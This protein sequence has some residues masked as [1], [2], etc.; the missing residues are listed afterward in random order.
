M[1]RVITHEQ[2]VALGLAPVSAPVK[3]AQPAPV[4]KPFTDNFLYFIEEQS[5]ITSG[6]AAMLYTKIINTLSGQITNHLR[7][8]CILRKSKKLEDTALF[9]EMNADLRNE[10]DENKRGEE[11]TNYLTDASGHTVRMPHLKA[12]GILNGIRHAVYDK[13]AGFTDVPDPAVI[14]YSI[15]NNVDPKALRA[16]P[17][18]IDLALRGMIDRAGVPTEAQ[19]AQAHLKAKAFQ[20][21]T[22]L[23]DRALELETKRQQRELMALYPD[24]IAEAKSLPAHDNEDDWTALDAIEREIIVSRVKNNL[25]RSAEQAFERAATARPGSDWEGQQEERLKDCEHA[26]SIVDAW[27]EMHPFKL[28]ET[29]SAAVKA[30]VTALGGAYKPK[31]KATADDDGGIADLSD[32]PLE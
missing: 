5:N 24:I 11:L 7:W 23:A 1:N 22:E 2:A 12:A 10:A 26:L 29:G 13:L 18:G 19:R 27:I 14:L 28:I 16:L 20:R 17:M 21:T 25:T 9:G 6:A 31:A 32:D 8:H 15:P 3:E 30:A 4:A